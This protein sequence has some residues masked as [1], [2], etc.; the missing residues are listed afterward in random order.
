MR[1]MAFGHEVL[2]EVEVKELNVG[3]GMTRHGMRDVK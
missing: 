2:P 3:T 1:S